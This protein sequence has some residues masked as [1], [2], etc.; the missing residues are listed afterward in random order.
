[1]EDKR[2]STSTKIAKMVGGLPLCFGFLG[3]MNC[4]KRVCVSVFLRFCV[5]FSLLYSE[6]VMWRLLM[7]I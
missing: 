5:S 1:M 2:S 7:M 3:R 4:T 6:M